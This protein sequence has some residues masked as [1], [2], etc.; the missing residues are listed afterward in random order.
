MHLILPGV[1]ITAGPQWAEDLNTS[2][3][4]IDAHDHS[5]G[6]G[7]QITPAGININAAFS[8][9][10]ENLTN[11]GATVFSA[12]ASLAD[13]TALYVIGDDLYYNDGNSNIVRITQ[14][15][16]V[17]G[18]PGSIT[19][20]VSPASASYSASTFVFQSNVNTAANMD[21]ASLKMRNTTVSSFAMTLN[22]PSGMGSNFSITFPTLPAANKIMAMDNSGNITA[23]IDVDNS[24]LQLGG[25]VLSVKNLGINTAQL[26]D[27]SVTQAKL[28]ADVI[29]SNVHT[30]TTTDLTYALP[31]GIK[32]LYIEIQGG[33]AG[34]GSGGS[35]ADPTLGGGGGGGGAGQYLAGIL[36]VDGLSTLSVTVGAG[37]AGGGAVSSGNGNAGVAGGSSIVVGNITLTALGGG[38]G[39]G[40][41]N[42]STSGAGGT[43]PSTTRYYLITGATGGQGGSINDGINVAGQSSL[44]FAGGTAPASNGN[45]GGGGGAGFYGAGG[46]GGDRP[47]SGAGNAGAA[48]AVA[49]SGAAGGG[50]SANGAGSFTTGAGGAGVAGKVTIYWS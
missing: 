27:A 16:N 49:N 25:N 39:A 12:V 41:T 10:N 2:L 47:N 38:G 5:P 21:I 9:N 23:V 4:L 20:L 33:G 3:T 44:F 17:A 46:N 7:V 26:A 28:A 37:G 36:N 50:G 18:T 34:G 19:G 42:S 6:Y 11:V 8:I 40:G 29:F 14:S 24:T 43:S 30:F 48:A 22:P 35:G 15:G 1:A 45:G 32:W 31:T 13:I